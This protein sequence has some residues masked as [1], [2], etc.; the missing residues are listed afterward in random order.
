VAVA[1]LIGGDHVKAGVGERRHLVPPGVGELRKTVAQHDRRVSGIAGLVHAQR[2]AV[3]IDVS[4][5]RL[6]HDTA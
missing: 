6:A 2:D 3:D 5:R 4:D 1:A